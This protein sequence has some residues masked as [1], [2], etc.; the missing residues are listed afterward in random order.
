[1]EAT[2]VI[3]VSHHQGAIDWEQV[4]NAGIAGVIIRCGYGM[5]QA[6]QDDREWKRN[7]DACARLGIPF[8][9]Y[10]YSYADS[11][12]RA[13]SEAQHALRLLAGYRLSYP[14]Y[15]DIEKA[16]TENGAAERARVFCEKIRSAGYLPGVYANK[17]WWD[18]YLTDLTEY[19]R[20]V[21]RYS[22]TLGM[23]DVDLW[24]YTSGGTVPGIVGR[25]DLNRCYR[26]FPAEI[27]PGSISAPGVPAKE[28]IKV[29]GKWGEATTRRLQQILGTAVDGKVSH[30]FA[31]YRASNPGL[32]Y[33]SFQWE[34]KPSGYSPVMKAF[35]GCLN[36]WIN[37]GLRDDGHIG[38]KTIRAIQTWLG[39]AADGHFDAV[40]PAIR[41]LQEW[42]NRQ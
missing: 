6:S 31:S 42:I 20:W 29:D 32:D 38:P 34:S 24:Q 30:Q 18:H 28:Q 25:V 15:Y 1:M 39:C 7:A 36:I 13:A 21:A 17:N 10:L 14:V 12:E 35:Q 2:K 3:D 11:I 5:D 27:G 23:E 19:T 41:K 40:S 22:D 33:G 26:D 9:A 8:G 4:K 16:G 37:A